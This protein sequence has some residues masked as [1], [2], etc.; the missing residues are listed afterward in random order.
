HN[1]PINVMDSLNNDCLIEI[2]KYLNLKDQI[3]LHQVNN[4]LQVTVTSLWLLKYKHVH[5]NFLEVPLSNQEFGLFLKTIQDIVE[6]LQL[7]FL[8]QDKYE[9]MKEFYFP[10]VKNF[11]FT[12]SKPYFMKDSDI[13]DLK[14][15]LPNLNA[16]SPHGNLTGLYMEEWSSLKDL[17]LSFCFKL[18]MLHFQT[19]INTLKLE[20]LK[21]NVF[22]NNNQFEQMNLVD[23]QVEDLK[24]LELNTYEFYYF[25]AKPLKA[26]KELV[27]TNHYNPRQLFD[28]LL[29]IWKANKIRLVETAN[30]DNIL[31]NCLEM[32]LNVEELT[33]VNDENPL[34]ANTITSLR[35]LTNLRKL[36]FRSCQIKSN[37]FVNLLKNTPQLNEISFEQCHFDVANICVKVEEIAVNRTEKLR[38]NMLENR[39]MDNLDRPSWCREMEDMVDI[40]VDILGDHNLLELTHLKGSDL[41]YEPL[42]VVFR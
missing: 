14:Q 20:K 12:L 23:A 19:I 2:I 26:L 22:P 6:V 3:T 35:L 7:R 33:I 29:S 40:L 39:L 4:G 38:L 25:L 34:P 24:Y 17:N 1:K 16:F 11:R 18:E 21:L 36:R 15:I 5:I 31:V 13:K 27:I 41:C 32:H 42:Y 9:I 10:Q 8:T 30:V 28:V 37:N